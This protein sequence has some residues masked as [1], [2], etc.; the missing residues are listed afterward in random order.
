MKSLKGFFSLFS[1]GKTKKRRTRGI[2]NKKQKRHT[3][4]HKMKGG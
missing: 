4:R 3:R 2:R 1:F